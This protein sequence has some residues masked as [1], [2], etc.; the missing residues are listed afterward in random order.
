VI[1][2]TVL[3]IFGSSCDE[4]VF[5]PICQGLKKQGIAYES[6]I[7]SAHKTPDE[8]DKVLKNEYDLII[9][10]AGLS[11]ALPGVIASKTISPII[12]V[13]VH[14]N[15]E[16]LDALLSIIQMPP[17]IP[18]LA[19]GVNKTDVAVDNAIKILTPHDGIVIIGDED[20]DV[21][22]K[23]EE[24]LK[25][26]EVSYILSDKV[27]K[28]KVNIECTYFDE[29]I[30]EKEDL[31]IYCPLITKKDDRAEA[32]INLLKHSTHGLWVGLNNAVNAAVAAVE[33]VNFD[34]RYDQALK[35]Y[36]EEMKKKLLAANKK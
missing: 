36:R 34:K 9:A 32:A 11:A 17:G 25:K 21:V 29:P 20:N 23:V 31:V 12:G 7:I 15:Y 2:I 8:L 26:F 10:G 28:D 5:K 24:T 6:R 30:D 16:G 3:I 4:K 33:I 1:K 13:P 35:N 19:V 18:V 14:V 27:D 22:K